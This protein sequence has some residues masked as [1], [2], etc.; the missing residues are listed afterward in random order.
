MEDNR[1]RLVVIVIGYTDRMTAFIES[2]PGLK[3]RFSRV[4][5]FPNYDVGEMLLIADRMAEEHHFVIEPSAHE[6]FGRLLSAKVEREREQFRN[7][8]GVRN[9]FEAV[10]GAQ[11]NRIVTMANPSRNDLMTITV[12]DVLAIQT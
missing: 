6:Q 7:A 10:I 5:G 11:A 3:S 8:R 2:N 9:L 1:D 4:I 12:E